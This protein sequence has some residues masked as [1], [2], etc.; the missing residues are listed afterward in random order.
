MIPPTT[1]P[2]VRQPSICSSTRTT[3]TTAV[4]RRSDSSAI[5]RCFWNPGD[6][7]ATTDELLDRTEK[8]VRNPAI[9]AAF[10]RIGLSGQ[11]GTGVRA[12]LSRLAASRTPSAG[13][14]QRQGEEDLRASPATRA[15]VQRRAA[16][17]T[18]AT[19][20]EAQRA[21]GA[22]LR[23]ARRQGGASLTDANAV[24]GQAGPEARKVLNT[25]A[26]QDCWSRWEMQTG[27]AY[28]TPQGQPGRRAARSVT[29]PA[30]QTPTWSLRC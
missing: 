4:R 6:A 27:T 24:T 28:R 26:I 11:A 9:V 25:L 29:K 30:V 17:A 3:A 16:T 21:A 7:F 14:K 10:R 19:R 12:I 5:G 8:E 13:N 2:S 23:L 1:L 18:G 22:T 15:A 20:R